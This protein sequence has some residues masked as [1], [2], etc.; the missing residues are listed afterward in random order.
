[1]WSI[2]EE[3]RGRDK[4]RETSKESGRRV[5]PKQSMESRGLTNKWL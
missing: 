2:A 4:V 1:M 3:T 5:M